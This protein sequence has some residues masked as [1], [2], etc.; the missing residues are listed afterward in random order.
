[1]IG[2]ALYPLL[3]GDAT[4]LGLLSTRVHPWPL[5]QEFA[6]PAVAYAVDEKPVEHCDGGLRI[7]REQ[8]V[9]GIFCE[10]LLQAETIGE[11]IVRVLDGYVG[12][13]N[14][15]NIA[16]IRLVNGENDFDQDMRMRYIRQV[17]NITILN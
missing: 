14:S 5:P 8:V 12:T 11:N 3:T 13:L 15:V 17:Y 16:S 4:L 10:N 1:M 7:I 6:T 9:I 2:K